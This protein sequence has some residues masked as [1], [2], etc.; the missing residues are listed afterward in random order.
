MKSKLA[1]IVIAVLAV[2][3][4]V[5]LL[6][7]SNDATPSAPRAG[8]SKSGAD[9]FAG[10]SLKDYSGNVITS[11]QFQGK[12]LVINSWAAWCPFCKQE[13]P[14]LA[15]AQKEFGDK[16]RIV[17]I[18]RGESLDVAKKYSDA[19]GTSAQLVFLLDPDDSFYKS[20]GGF[21]MPETIFV[22]KNGAIAIHKRGPM[23]IREIREKINQLLAQ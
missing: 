12:P 21:S 13:L 7:R 10:F 4:G 9:Q 22:D 3:A 6:S 23:D 18:D 8:E 20:I 1:Y 16:V 11:D 2:L 19:Q 5:F 17:A 15:A 14:D